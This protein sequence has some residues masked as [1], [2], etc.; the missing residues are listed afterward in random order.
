MA[1][2]SHSSKT[3]HGVCG[4]CQ[5][6]PSTLARRSGR[7]T[8]DSWIGPPAT[9][10]KCK[11]NG[12]RANV[13]TSSVRSTGADSDVTDVEIPVLPELQHKQRDAT[14]LA[15]LAIV[16]RDGHLFAGGPRRPC[17]RPSCK[18]VPSRHFELLPQAHHADSNHAAGGTT[19][20]DAARQE[21]LACVRPFPSSGRSQTFIAPTCKTP[22]PACAPP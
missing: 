13:L 22:Y 7:P 10:K 17:K 5:H 19:E 1:E 12:L 11:R 18:A 6:T 2:S 21:A 4:H 3:A 20:E 9:R 8:L 16:A 15:L 14:S